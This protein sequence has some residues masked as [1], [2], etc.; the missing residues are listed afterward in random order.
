MLQLQANPKL[1]HRR[2]PP[3]YIS[4]SSNLPKAV[5][6]PR[7]MNSFGEV[8]FHKIKLKSKAGFKKSLPLTEKFVEALLKVFK[9]SQI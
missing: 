1:G 3:G 8:D 5:S 7:A 9:I 4:A 6:G 2:K